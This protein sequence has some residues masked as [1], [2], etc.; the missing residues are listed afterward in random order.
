MFLPNDAG[1]TIEKQ[2]RNRWVSGY[3]MDLSRSYSSWPAV[4]HRFIVIC[5]SFNNKKIYLNFIT[6]LFFITFIRKIVGK[7][8]TFFI[9]LFFPGTKKIIF[10]VFSFFNT[11]IIFTYNLCTTF[12]PVKKIYFS[13]F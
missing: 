11:K 3:D 1:C 4:S 12:F 2:S 8:W 10:P 7:S 13:R 6:G 5:R 9:L